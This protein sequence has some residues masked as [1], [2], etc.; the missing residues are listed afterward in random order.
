MLRARLAGA[1][2]AAGLGLISGCSSLSNSSWFH[3]NRAVPCDGCSAGAVPMGE[4]P[5]LEGG[6]AVMVPG[7]MPTGPMPAPLPPDASM[8]S[9]TQPPRLVPQ[10]QAQPVPASPSKRTP[11]ILSDIWRDR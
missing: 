9:M 1:L 3:R 11:G 2:V 5:M 10:P 8:P 6:S 7:E 4:G